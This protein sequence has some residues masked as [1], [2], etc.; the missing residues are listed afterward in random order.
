MVKN[1]EKESHKRGF[2]ERK[3]VSSQKSTKMIQTVRPIPDHEKIHSHYPIFFKEFYH[4]FFKRNVR[5]KL[6]RAM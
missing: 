4:K 5:S 1:E 2:R 3:E 6:Q